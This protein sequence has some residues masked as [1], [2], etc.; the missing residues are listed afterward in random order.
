[1]DKYEFSL[2]P[3][4]ARR[5]TFRS[6]RWVVSTDPASQ[7]RHAQPPAQAQG[8]RSS[9]PDQI[10]QSS[11]TRLLKGN[12]SKRTKRHASLTALYTSVLARQSG[13]RFSPIYADRWADA[14]TRLAGDDPSSDA[15]DDLLV[16]LTR[17]GKLSPQE[18]VKMV[19][20]HHRSAR[21]L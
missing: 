20:A 7:S 5:G 15:T 13:V 6:R 21:A 14:V 10:K 16:A 4:K 3:F 19:I 18:M 2:R 1:M 9:I 11:S 12:R 17:A 8:V